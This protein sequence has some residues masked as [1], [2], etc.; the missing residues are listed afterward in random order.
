MNSLVFTSIYFP[1]YLIFR[2][3]K[4]DSD[5]LS[6]SSFGTDL[7][8]P[9]IFKPEGLLLPESILSFLGGLP[10]FLPTSD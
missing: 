6:T 1:A 10:L 4:R 7:C 9:A 2:L 3:F 5:Y 8:D